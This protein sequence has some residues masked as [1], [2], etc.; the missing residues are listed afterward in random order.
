MENDLLLLMEKYIILNEIDQ[1][2]RNA[3][4]TQIFW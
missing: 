3:N 2:L 1:K 4:V